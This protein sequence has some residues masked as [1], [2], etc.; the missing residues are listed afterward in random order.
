MLDQALHATL[1][2]AAGTGVGLLGRWGRANA[3]SLAPAHLEVY[4]RERRI[5]ALE[6][7]ASACYGAALVLVAAAVLAL[8]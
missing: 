2:L 3:V 4:D 8:L 5:R 6:R 1:L 7:G